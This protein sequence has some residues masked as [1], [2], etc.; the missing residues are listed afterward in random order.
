MQTDRGVSGTLGFK[1][2]EIS[3]K[4][5]AHTAK[6]NYFVIQD[7]VQNS[8]NVFCLKTGEIFII[9]IC[10]LFYSDGEC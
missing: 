4:L 9:I 10:T 6:Y 2:A 8:L 5:A 3:M 7:F 1:V